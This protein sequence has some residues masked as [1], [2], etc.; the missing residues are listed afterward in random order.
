MKRKAIVLL[1]V[2]LPIAANSA[3]AKPKGRADGRPKE[4][5]SDTGVNHTVQRGETLFSLAEKYYGDGYAWVR[6]KEYNPWVDQDHLNIG[7]IIHI[8]DPKYV[9]EGAAASGDSGGGG[10]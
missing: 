9:P 8:P 2:L 5:A 7:E 1:L 4:T 6:I 3:D 10:S